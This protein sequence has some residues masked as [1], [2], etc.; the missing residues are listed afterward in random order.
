MLRVL[1]MIDAG[2]SYSIQL[3][4]TVELTHS[5]LDLIRSP[6]A[7]SSTFTPYSDMN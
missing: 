7:F 2:S 1:I 6:S 3:M 5:D 4:L